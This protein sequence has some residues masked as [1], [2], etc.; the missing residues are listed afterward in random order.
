MKEETSATNGSLEAGEDNRG[1]VDMKSDDGFGCLDCDVN[2]AERSSHF[3]QDVDTELDVDVVGFSDSATEQVLGDDP[4]ATEYSSS[5]GDTFS[6]S[7]EQLERESS[8]AEVDSPFYGPLASLTGGFRMFRKKKLTPH[9]QKYVHPLRWRCNWLELR[10]KEL[11]S[12]AMKYEKELLAYD[13][14]KLSVFDTFASAD[15]VTRTVPF[16]CNQGKYAMKRR[17][18][19]KIEDKVDVSSY[20]SCHNIFS[21]Y[22][23][24]IEADGLSVDDGF[25]D[26]VVLVDQ[27]VRGHDNFASNNEWLILD[28]I[29]GDNSLEH[30]L[31]EIETVQSRVVKLRTQLNKMV[32]RKATRGLTFSI[33]QR[34]LVS[35]SG[36]SPSN[37]PVRNGDAPQPD[38]PHTPPNYMSESETEDQIISESAVSSFGDAAPNIIESTVSLL[39]VDQ[40]DV[41]NAH[42]DVGDDILISNQAAKEELQNFEKVEHSP[43]KHHEM[44]KEEEGSTAP[45]VAGSEAGSE[46][47]RTV[48]GEPVL[49]QCSETVTYVRRSK[50][51]RVERRLSPS[52]WHCEKIGKRKYSKSREHS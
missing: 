50:R 25:G 51:P 20:M 33:V 31:L 19:Q 44:T 37:S 43:E 26:T 11:Q 15:S 52:S 34:D 6:G 41:G 35:S 14:E 3:N 4:D 38:T 49:K 42:D 22:E 45:K 21:Y 16:I 29:D 2:L 46:S 28:F 47:E 18:R 8:D 5:F 23:K 32:D 9:W 12:Q 27:N 36:R 17:Q 24:G 7:D 39:A 40:N 48:L 30:L 10:M 13:K 1:K